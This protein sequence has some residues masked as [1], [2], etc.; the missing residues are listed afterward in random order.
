MPRLKQPTHNF[1]ID[2][3]AGYTGVYLE[4]SKGG[5]YVSIATGA[6][7][8][9]ALKNAESRLTRLTGQI[10]RKR[11]AAERRATREKA[12]AMKLKAAKKAKKGRGR[13]AA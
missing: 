9:A 12:K 11:M 3:D 8:L 13:K 6:D 2:T 5:A 7:E 1:D 4:E 10:Q